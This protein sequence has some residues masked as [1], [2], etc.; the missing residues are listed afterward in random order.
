MGGGGGGGVGGGGGGEGFAPLLPKNNA[1]FSTE[2][3]PEKKILS[4]LRVSIFF[5]SGNHI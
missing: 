4:F 5:Y 3:I 2:K 1:L